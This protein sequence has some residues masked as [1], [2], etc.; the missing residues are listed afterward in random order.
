[1]SWIICW[2]IILTI[3]AV[4]VLGS[5]VTDEHISKL[6][7]GTMDRK[8]LDEI[9]KGL[10]PDIIPHLDAVLKMLPLPPS[11]TSSCT[12]R[13]LKYL[14]MVTGSASP[15]D[16]KLAIEL[17]ANP[18]LELDQYIKENQL[19]V[20]ERLPCILA[21]TRIIV[22]L[23]KFHYNRPRP[24]QLGWLLGVP[25]SPLPSRSSMTPSYISAD[26]T[27]AF[28]YART[29]AKDNPKHAD[30]LLSIADRVRMSREIGGWHFPSDTDAAV[31]VSRYL[32]DH[33]K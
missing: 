10:S 18:L 8:C 30:A 33:L 16:K 19:K 31:N 12:L 24:H 14:Q 11:N 13:E 21:K 28:V 23:I 5:R 15:A 3:L 9:R 20:S 26:V 7:F 27:L 2:V 22:L 29:V 4:Y 32:S 17:D 25:I 6:R 1:M